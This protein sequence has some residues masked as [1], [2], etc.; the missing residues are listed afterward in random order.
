[1]RIRDFLLALF[2][3]LIVTFVLACLYV[4]FP[5]ISMLTKPFWSNE[6]D[7]SG[8]VAIA[9]GVSSTGVLALLVVETSVFLVIFGLLNRKRT[10]K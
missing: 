8:I 5:L 3:S 7:T 6:P 4:F 9:G 2:L 1:M 10:N